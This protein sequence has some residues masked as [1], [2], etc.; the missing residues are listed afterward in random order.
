MANKVLRKVTH[1][2]FDMDGLLLGECC[3]ACICF[4]C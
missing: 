1:C 2:V 3:R 4:L